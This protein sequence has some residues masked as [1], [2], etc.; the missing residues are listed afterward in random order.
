[1]RPEE[2]PEAPSA[3]WRAAS[4]FVMGAVG[5]L[6]SGFL[7]V[8]SRPEVHGMDDFLRL[9]D[10]REKVENRERGL[11][12]VSNHISVLDDPLLWGVLPLS[13]VFSPNNLRWGL[14]S[15]DLCFQNKA[16]STFFSLGQVLPTH[17]TAHSKHGGLFQPTI[18]QAI[19]L[20]S[21]GPFVRVN[22][23]P[24]KPETSLSSPDLSDPFSGG[25]LTFSTNGEDTF[26]A[27]SA[28]MSRRHAWVHV[29]PEGMIHQTEDRIMR[30][31]KWGVSRLILESD[32]MPDVVPIFIEGFDD[33]MDE[34]RT[35]PKFIPRPFK[36]I[37]VTFG[38]RLD[39]EE[40]F[41]D[42]RERWRQIRAKE[43]AKAGSKLEVGVLNN[44]LKY[45]EEVVSLRMECT[46]RVRQAVL[47]VR[48][49][50]GYSDEDPKNN[51]ATTWLREGPKADGRKDDGSIT[52]AE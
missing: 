16:T 46:R 43:E 49:Q 12:T 34:R 45:S 11:L 33:V 6:C 15:Y 52:K 50:R 26:P 39:A 31:F 14:G 36:N 10:E 37:R 30:Y 35:F 51:L 13:Y 23:A 40:A 27:P 3:P 25:H 8:W 28:Y 44:A 20:L 42:L 5:V 4:T 2:Q 1:M 32:P 48:R 47:D 18:T 9:L 24:G 41:G 19:R 21:R 7:N 29:F 17:R 38:A 22:D